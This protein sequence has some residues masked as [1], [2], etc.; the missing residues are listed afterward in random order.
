MFHIKIYNTLPIKNGEFLMSNLFNAWPAL[1]PP[2][3]NFSIWVVVVQR[4]VNTGAKKT[5]DMPRQM[6]HLAFIP[7]FLA[8][9]H[10]IIICYLY[11]RLPFG[12]YPYTIYMK[13]PPSPLYQRGVRGDFHASLWQQAMWV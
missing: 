4:Q 8:E 3:S 13:N 10:D 12:G 2:D 7:L 11:V 1:G 6:N 9:N 5:E